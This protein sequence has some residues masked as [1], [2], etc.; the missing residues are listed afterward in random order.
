M[1]YILFI[2]MILIYLFQKAPTSTGGVILLSVFLCEDMHCGVFGTDDPGSPYRRQNP[3]N[4]A[5][6]PTVKLDRGLMKGQLRG[7]R[8]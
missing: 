8:P 7:D 5:A 1:K 6:K 4:V 2:Y 3:R